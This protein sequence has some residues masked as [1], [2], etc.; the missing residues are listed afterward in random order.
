MRLRWILMARDERHRRRK[1][2]VGDGNSGVRGRRDPSR[3]SRNDFEGDRRVVHCLGFFAAAAKYERIAALEA[4]HA[5]SVARQFHEQLIDLLLTDRVLGATTF[6]DVKQLGS[7]RLARTGWKQC[8]IGERVIDNGVGR[9]YQLLPPHGD[10]IRVARPRTDEENLPFSH[11]TQLASLKSP[12]C[13]AQR[14]YSTGE[15]SD[16]LISLRPPQNTL[17]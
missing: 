17:V 1:S 14:A 5:F 2:P 16:G 3:D 15:I 11:P 7:S 10:Q 9:F 8:R 4:H 12:I 13:S 6:A